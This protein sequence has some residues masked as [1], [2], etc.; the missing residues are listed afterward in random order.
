MNIVRSFFQ[1]ED[2]VSGFGVDSGGGGG[3]GGVAAG[4]SAMSGGMAGTSGGYTGPG[5]GG[6]AVTAA[7]IYGQAVGVGKYHAFDPKLIF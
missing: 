3:G 7:D 5:G 4:S 6:Y 2:Y 1:D